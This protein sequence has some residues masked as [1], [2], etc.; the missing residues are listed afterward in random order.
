MLGETYYFYAAFENSLYPDYVSEKF[1]RT[2]QLGIVPVV[3]GGSNYSYFA[4][5]KSYID[6]ND[7]KSTEELAKYL[8]YLIENPKEYLKYF[9]W[10]D[11]FEFS[12]ENYICNICQKI[13]E[14]SITSRSIYYKSIKKWWLTTVIPP[15]INFQDSIKSTTSHNNLTFPTTKTP[16]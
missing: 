3:L 4:P 12:G 1:F 10:R 15:K 2:I 9:W 6:V 7:F 16:V 13:H 11:L 5:P 8:K 14:R